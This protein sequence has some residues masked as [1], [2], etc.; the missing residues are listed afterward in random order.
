MSDQK[1]EWQ[2]SEPD[3]VV[4]IPRGTGDEDN[5]HFLVFEAPDNGLLALWT[6]SS[7]EGRGDN[8][9]MLSRSPDGDGWSEPRRVAG[10]RPQSDDLQASW[11]FPIVTRSGRIYVFFTREKPVIDNNRQGSG[12][13]GCI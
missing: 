11:G 3:A 7:C 10:A 1:N 13:M 4:Y 9:L 6:Q 8:R 12:A 2:R 5:E